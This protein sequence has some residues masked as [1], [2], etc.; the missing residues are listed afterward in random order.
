MENHTRFLKKLKTE[1]LYDP[2]IPLLDI[3]VKKTIA[4]VD[5]RTSM[6]IAALFIIAKTWKQPKYPSI[7]EWITVVY[8]CN[9]IL[10]IKN[11][12]IL[13]FVTIWMDLEGDMLSEI[14]QKDKDKYCMISL[15]CG[16]Q[17]T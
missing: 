7:D 6:F 9:G 2:A 15:I 1:L 17:K 10:V 4:L 11:S 16:I 5:I 3:Y 13:P 12:E 8:T 14:S